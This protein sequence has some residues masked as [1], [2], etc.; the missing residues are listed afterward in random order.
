MA[1]FGDC[2]DPFMRLRMASNGYEAISVCHGDAASCVAASPRPA[3]CRMPSASPASCFS[4][5]L[6]LTI[7]SLQLRLRFLLLRFVS[8]RLLCFALLLLRFRCTFCSAFR[9]CY[10]AV[11]LLLAYLAK[12]R[13]LSVPQSHCLSPCV[14]LCVHVSLCVP[15]CV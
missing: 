8:F 4:A 10:L 2:C 12:C 7:F 11:C 3:A 5:F 9:S 1:H 13:R 6:V 15:V 14:S